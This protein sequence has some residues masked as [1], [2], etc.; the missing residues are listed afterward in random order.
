MVRVAG[1]FDDARSMVRFYR[2][3][4]GFAREAARLFGSD[5]PV[6]LLAGDKPAPGDVVLLR[7]GRRPFLGIAVPLGVALRTRSGVGRTRPGEFTILAAW[8]RPWPSLPRS[9]PPSG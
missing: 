6:D 4:A 8:R 9:R 1:R 2:D 3:E 7:V 5:E